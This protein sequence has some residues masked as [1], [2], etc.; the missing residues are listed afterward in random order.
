MAAGIELDKDVERELVA[1]IQGYLDE[2]M[3]IEIGSFQAQFLLDF[4]AE[5]AGCRFYNQGLKDALAAISGRMEELDE[6]IYQLEIEPAAAD[7]RR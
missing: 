6:L 5:H 4:F 2:E 7:R 3:G 1:A